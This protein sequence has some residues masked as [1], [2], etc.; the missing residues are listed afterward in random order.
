MMEFF[1]SIKTFLVESRAEL[2]KV[3][4]PTREGVKDSTAVVLMTVLIVLILFVIYDYFF[5]HLM[6]ALA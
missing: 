4:W 1:R 5:S 6:A 3:S 2:R